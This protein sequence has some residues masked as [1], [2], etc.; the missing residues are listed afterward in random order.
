MLTDERIASLRRLFE[1]EIPFHR[2]LGL[3]VLTAGPAG[4]AVTIPPA[5]QL[6][7][8]PHRPAVHGGVLATL[9]DTAGGL[10]VFLA[11]GPGDRVSTLD[12]RVDYLRPAATDR[13]LTAEARV[14]RVGNR[15]AVTEI[16]VHHGDP[17]A[18][19]ARGTAVYNV[20]PP[21]RSAP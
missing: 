5:P 3:R 1:E 20:S 21:P 18:A 7:G 16:W 17:E 13:P 8:D 10:A 12:L 4:A 2:A 9:I 19:V 15:V 14:L 6:T 11:V